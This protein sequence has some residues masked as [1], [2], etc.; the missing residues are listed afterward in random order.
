MSARARFGLGALL[1]VA[2]A[3]AAHALMTRAPAS[4]LALLA[5]LGPMVGLGLVNLWRKGLRWFAALGFG[6]ALWLMLQST[7]EGAIAPPQLLYLA[8]HA[9]IHAGLCL[10]FGATLRG[11][12]TALITAIALRLHRNMQPAMRDYTR[13]VTQVWTGYFAAMVLLSLGLYQ[14]APFSAWSL[15]ANL[16]T[17]VSA[18]ALFVGEFVLRYRLHPEFERASLADAV[19]AYMDHSPA[20]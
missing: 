13:R 16:W 12:R 10:W 20:R 2:Y 5:L 15:F 17:P 9:G 1:T 18:C 7:G 8:Q 3:F 6:L 19:R 4:P 14:W 11:G